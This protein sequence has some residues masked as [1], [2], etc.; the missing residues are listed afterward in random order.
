MNVITLC[1]D[2]GNTRLKYGVFKND[3]LIDSDGLMDHSVD[4]IKKLLDTYKPQRTMLSSVIHHDKKVEELLHDKSDLILLDS[5]VRLP[6]STPVGKP[7]SIGADRLAISAYAVT[8]YPN[9]NNLIIALGSCITYNFVNKYNYFLGGGISPGMGMRFRGMHEYTAR[10]PLINSDWQFPLVGYD[11]RTN[12]LSGVMLGMAEEINGI[13]RR[14]EEKF[15]NFNVL[16]TG[17]D[18]VDFACHIKY[19]IF[20]DPAL[21]LKGLYAISKYNHENKS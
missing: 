21:I 6:F 5:N 15:L 16:L 11:T 20:A 9:K 18:S 1:L 4:T 7:E 10:L 12:M 13:I 2:F 17:G 3:E 14:Y 19:K 8:F